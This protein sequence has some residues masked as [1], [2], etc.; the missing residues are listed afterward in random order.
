VSRDIV[1]ERS[2]DERRSLDKSD[3][4]LKGCAARIAYVTGCFK[5]EDG[6]RGALVCV[7]A[8]APINI[9]I[10]SGTAFAVRRTKVP[11]NK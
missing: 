1:H 9:I 11:T 7:S 2:N 8:I 4:E 3:D 6:D 5:N 10:G